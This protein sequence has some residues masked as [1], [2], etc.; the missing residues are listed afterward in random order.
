[1]LSV[2]PFLPHTV[3]GDAPILM[4]TA[5]TATT[6]TLSWNPPSQPNGHI[7]QYT[8]R[9]N[10]VASI[11]LMKLVATGDKRSMELEGLHPYTNYSILF[12]ASTAVGEGPSSRVVAATGEDG[13][14]GKGNPKIVDYI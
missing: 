9:Y 10:P 2:S 5:F 12:S 1:M 6:L 8:I 14:G 7:T 13:E 4:V 11:D 3:P